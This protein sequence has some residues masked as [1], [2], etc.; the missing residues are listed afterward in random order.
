MAAVLQVVEKY[1]QNVKKAIKIQCKIIMILFPLIVY[2]QITES[3]HYLA[4][5][6]LL[7]VFI[8]WVMF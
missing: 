3:L 5:Y 6:E 8:Q 4:L 2:F 7:N 1:I